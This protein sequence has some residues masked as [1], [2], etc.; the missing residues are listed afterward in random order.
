MKSGAEAPEGVGLPW[1]NGRLVL[2]P[3]P[4]CPLG[5]DCS[6]CDGLK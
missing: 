2:T 1:M 6:Y 4:L 5:I 3:Q